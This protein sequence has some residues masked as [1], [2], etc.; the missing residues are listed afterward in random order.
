MKSG[1]LGFRFFCLDDQLISRSAVAWRRSSAKDD[2][3][4]RDEQYHQNASADKQFKKLGCTHILQ[5]HSLIIAT[6][7]ISA[8]SQGRV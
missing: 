8:L 2:S 4:Q 1:S 6:D 5:S 7:E 3:H